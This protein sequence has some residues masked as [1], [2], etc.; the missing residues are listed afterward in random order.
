LADR[1]GDVTDVTKPNLKF[2]SQLPSIDQKWQTSVCRGQWVKESNGS[3]QTAPFQ[4]N[5]K[6]ETTAQAKQKAAAELLPTSC[7]SRAML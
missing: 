2:K 5:V 4:D 3:M 6:L 1:G 7:H